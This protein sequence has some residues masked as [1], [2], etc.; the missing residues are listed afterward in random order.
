MLLLLFSRALHA[1]V[2]VSKCASPVLVIE[3]QDQDSQMRS[4]GLI[5][6]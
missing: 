4:E 3:Q 1:C 6:F 2:S 5:L